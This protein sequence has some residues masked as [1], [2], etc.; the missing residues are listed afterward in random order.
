MM[1][2]SIVMSCACVACVWLIAQARLLESVER[3]KRAEARFRASENAA[4]LASLGCEVKRLSL[5][6]EN[7]QGRVRAN[8]P[9]LSLAMAVR[10]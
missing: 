6:V 8:Q 5:Q 9:D 3:T 4:L 1:G 10:R 7:L 2:A